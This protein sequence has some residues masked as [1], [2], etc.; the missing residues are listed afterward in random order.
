[1]HA[2]QMDAN[3]SSWAA[4]G[5]PG[6]LAFGASSGDYYYLRVCTPV[7]IDSEHPTRLN[8]SCSGVQ[9]LS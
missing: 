9:E 7:R 6:R 1:V 4:F 3:S 5:N 8:L 2:L